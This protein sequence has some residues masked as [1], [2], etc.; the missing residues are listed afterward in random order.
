MTAGAKQNRK[1][2]VAIAA[3]L[4]RPTIEEAAQLAGIGEKTLRRWL[5]DDA[6]FKAAYRELGIHF[7]LVLFEWP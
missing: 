1:R 3:L 7:A 5:R 2:E 4:S 6:D